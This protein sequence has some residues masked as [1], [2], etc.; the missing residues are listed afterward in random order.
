MSI[1]VPHTLVLLF[2]M[3]IFAL[4][5][6]FILPPGTFDRETNDH[7][8][9]QVIAGSYKA[10]E[11]GEDNTAWKRITGMFLAIPKGFTKAEDIIFFVFIIGGA[12][13]VIRMTGMVDAVLDFILR[14]FGR[15]Q[16]LLIL[17]GMFIF[18]AGS[19][20]LGMAEEYLPFVPLLLALS[21]GMKLDPV[22]GIGILCVGYG[23]GY[24]VAAV[25]PFTVVV[26]QTVSGLQPQ[27]GWWYRLILTVPF[28]ALGVIH[29]WRYAAKIRKDPTKSLVYDLKIDRPEENKEPV[30][31]TTRHLLIVGVTFVAMGLIVWGIGSKEWYLTEMGGIFFALT[32][33]VA[34]LARIR[35]D[36]AASEFCKGAAELTT[37]ALLIGFARSVEVV[38]NEG[39]I[40]DTIINGIATPLESL[41]PELSAMGMFAVQ[42]FTNVFIPSGSGQA[43]VT[44][45]VMAPLADICGVERQVAVLAYQFGDGFTNI[46]VPT[47]G[48]LMG[49]LALAGIP[50]DR[51]FK[52]LFPLMIQVWILGCLALAVAVWIGYS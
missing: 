26:A 8:R 44:M 23:I 25:N 45:P 15:S 36:A 27:S 17:F 42:S 29:V 20:S 34:I 33:V 40:I 2:G 10:I 46:I 21:W 3:L 51:W 43:Y 24:G 18:T 37:T 16:N 12:L 38:L 49:I 19:S 9:E 7:G 32:I 50:Y 47:N 35:P 5:L 13:A 1:K 52:F 30:P 28:F 41:G 39:Q 14:K 48:V 11:R 31:L 4:L 22:V 6:T